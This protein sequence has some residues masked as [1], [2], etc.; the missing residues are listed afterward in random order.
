[1]THPKLNRAYQMK[2]KLRLLFKLSDEDKVVSEQ[3]KWLSRTQRCRIPEFVE[4]GK[5]IKRHYNS[6]INTITLKVSSS[7]IESTNNKIKL[8]IRKA[9]GF[10]NINNQ[11]DMIYLTCSNY[12]INLPC[13][14][15]PLA[16]YLR[17]KAH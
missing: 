10:R 12:K 2:E 3:N 1:M 11:K 4:L 7:K 17:L 13:R 14:G 8:L 15:L 16:T 5:K 6:I 9:Y